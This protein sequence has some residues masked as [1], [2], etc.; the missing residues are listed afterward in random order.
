MAM[1]MMATTKTTKPAKGEATWK[2]SL[3]SEE[4]TYSR[5]RNFDEEESKFRRY[6]L[7]TF[8]KMKRNSSLN[9]DIT[10]GRAKAEDR[11]IKDSTQDKSSF[12]SKSFIPR[13]PKKS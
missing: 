11:K 5:T 2:P 8:Q 13:V 9:N 1:T 12:V 4:S 7:V 3:H 10:G 6:L